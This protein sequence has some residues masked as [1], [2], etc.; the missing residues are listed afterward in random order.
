MSRMVVIQSADTPQLESSAVML[1][2]AGYDDVR[3]CGP[4]L[5]AELLRIGCDT[6]LAPES[7]Y[8]LGYDNLDPSIKAASLA[9]MDRADLFCEIKCRNVDKILKR[10]PRLRNRIAWWRVNGAQPEICPKGGDEVNLPCPVITACLWYGLAR[11]RNERVDCK[12]CAGTGYLPEARHD[13]D[14]GSDPRCFYCRSTGKR[15]ACVNQ[16]GQ[17]AV[18]HERPNQAMTLADFMALHQSNKTGDHGYAY[19]FWP[20]YPRHKDYEHFRRLDM[21]WEPPYSMCHSIRAWGFGG[22][23]DECQKLGVRM[24]GNN[25][26]A[27]QVSH[28]MV[29]SIAANALC[30]VHLK[31]VDC[32]GWALYEAMLA[33]CPVVVPRLM[34]SRMLAYDLLQDGV[35]CLEYGTHATLEYG[36]GDPKLDDCLK[37]IIWSLKH[38]S[39]PA[40]NRLIGEAGRVRLNELMWRADRDGDSFRAFCQRNF[41]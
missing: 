2:H 9:D 21:G 27:G 20:P 5:R 6:V 17:S 12:E 4:S 32:P 19:T 7:M 25:S 23:I 22:I 31:S 15:L 28:N 14:Y 10:W 18:E 13:K 11:Y 16:Q 40:T 24:Y 8:A 41:E 26:P 39:D 1:R 36:R 29:P 33:G 38:L 3:H 30:L 34:N 35:T 37:D